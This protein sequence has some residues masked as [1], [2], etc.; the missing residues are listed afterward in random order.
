M[1]MFYLYDQLSLSVCSSDFAFT[2]QSSKGKKANSKTEQTNE[3][4]SPPEYIRPGA[5]ERPLLAT[6]LP[7]STYPEVQGEHTHTY[8]YTFTLY[9]SK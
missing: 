9:F 4:P 5:I 1:Q 2:S 3:I 8:P 6:L 7:T